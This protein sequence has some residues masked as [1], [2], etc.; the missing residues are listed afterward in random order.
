MLIVLDSASLGWV[1]KVEFLTSIQ[2]LILLVQKLHFENVPLRV[3][4]L[5]K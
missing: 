2:G 3:R 4:Q 5:Y 1:Q